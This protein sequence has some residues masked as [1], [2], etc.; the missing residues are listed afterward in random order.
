MWECNKSCDSER[1]REYQVLQKK[2]V[3]SETMRERVREKVTSV[4]LS[5]REWELQVQLRERVTNA[6][7]IETESNKCNIVKES[8]ISATA[9]ESE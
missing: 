5:E 4:T 6:T 3:I 9:R 7:V 1:K 8:I 2:S